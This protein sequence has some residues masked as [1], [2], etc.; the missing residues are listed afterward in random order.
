MSDP[1]AAPDPIDE[2]YVQ[3]EALLS[4]DDARAARRARVLAAVAREPAPRPAASAGPTRSPAWRRGGWLAAA[5]VAG[6]SV[7]IA[8]QLYEPLPRQPQTAPTS[9]AGPV[10]AAP[11]TAAPVTAAPVTAAPVSAAPVSAA[12]IAAAPKAPAPG[13]A[14]PEI[15][16]APERPAPSEA[17]T[18]P[19][20]AAKAAAQAPASPPADIAPAAS[21]PPPPLAPARRAAPAEPATSSV[22]ELVVTRERAENAAA[23]NDARALAGGDR[24][25]EV[26]VTASKRATGSA[27]AAPP[28]ASQGR[29]AARPSGQAAKL[30]AAAAA[31]RTAEVDALLEQGAPVD[32]PDAD[33]NTALMKSLQA[34]HPAAAAAL[35]RHGASLDRK[36]HAGES[37]RDMAT[38]KDDPELSQAIGLAP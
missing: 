30:R 32:A 16:A 12:P 2:A 22:S 4:D 19:A 34:D 9:P 8:S 38:A 13:P 37:A 25:E 23:A 33:G 24:D 35:R 5:C 17:R 18:A 26:T 31:G 7:F 6:L 14:A 15:A 27:F 11:V 1:G 29:L 3:A 36:N 10:T 20:D 28:V 21:P